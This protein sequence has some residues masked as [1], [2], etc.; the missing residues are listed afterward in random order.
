M[1]TA[2]VEEQHVAAGVAAVGD[3]DPRRYSICWGHQLGGDGERPVLGVRGERFR[4]RADLSEV[5]VAIA[6]IAR[7]PE[8]P[9]LVVEGQDLEPLRLFPP[10]VLELGQ[11]LRL[12]VGQVGDLGEILSHVV[13]F[14]TFSSSNGLVVSEPS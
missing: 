8:E 13:G 9:G 14:Q 3:D 1:Q 5:F 10:E 2:I 4:Q 12:H 7:I 11:L 6:A